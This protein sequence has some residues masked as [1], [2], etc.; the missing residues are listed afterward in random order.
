MCLRAVIKDKI[1]ITN[2]SKMTYHIHSNVNESQNYDLC[3]VPYDIQQTL[4]IVV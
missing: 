2:E 1:T 3:D 4:S